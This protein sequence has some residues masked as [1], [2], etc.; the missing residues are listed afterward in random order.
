MTF[1]TVGS[2]ANLKR[3]GLAETNKCHLCDKNGTTRHI[4]SACKVALSEGRYRYRH[5]SV[6][7]AI[8]HAIQQFINFTKERIANP[9]KEI[10]SYAK[11]GI[12]RAGCSKSADLNGVQAL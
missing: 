8:A 3:W 10:I 12:Q 5:D 9:R 1:D 4:L 11:E 2:P 6:L 7:K